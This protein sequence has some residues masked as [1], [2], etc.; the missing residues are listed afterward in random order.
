MITGIIIGAI[1][2]ILGVILSPLLLLPD[3]VI[4]PHISANI[5]SFGGFIQ[6]A[7]SFFPASTLLTILALIL[8]IDGVIFGYKIFMWVAR[9]LP[10]VK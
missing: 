9:K 10:F 4:D 3:V 1:F 7:N 6:N 8:A 2:T 5:A